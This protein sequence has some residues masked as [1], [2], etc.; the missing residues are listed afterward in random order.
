MGEVPKW[1]CR[2]GASGETNN[3]RDIREKGRVCVA[4]CGMSVEVEV[5]VAEAANLL[6]LNTGEPALYP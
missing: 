5:A 1:R 2:D 3:Q 6:Y 4:I